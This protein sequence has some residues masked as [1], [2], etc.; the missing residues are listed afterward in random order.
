[1]YKRLLALT[2]LGIATATIFATSAVADT[3]VQ[4]IRTTASDS[5]NSASSAIVTPDTL[6][7]SQTFVESSRSSMPTSET[8]VISEKLAGKPDYQH[9]LDLMKDQMDNA[10]DKGWLSSADASFLQ[11]RYSDL[12]SSLTL[13]RTHGFPSD[14]AQ[15][16]EKQFTAFNI[17]LSDKMAAGHKVP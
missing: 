6:T 11:N 1:M 9:R 3:A 13:V 4:I 15:A 7:R 5:P 14:E 17:E 2:L 12:A 8:T 10:I 16:L